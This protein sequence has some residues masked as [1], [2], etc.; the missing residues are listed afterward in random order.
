MRMVVEVR[1]R[2]DSFEFDGRVGGRVVVAAA[3][4]APCTSPVRARAN[5]WRKPRWSEGHLRAL[6]GLTELN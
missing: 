2:G 5:K 1:R 4:G 3:A 6:E